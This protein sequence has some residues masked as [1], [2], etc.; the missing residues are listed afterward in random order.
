M[1]KTVNDH[2]A[3]DL[4]L[5]MAALREA[6]WHD[7]QRAYAAAAF[8]GGVLAAIHAARMAVPCHSPAWKALN[9]V[10]DA[11]PV[12]AHYGADTPKCQDNIEV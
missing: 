10:Y 7:C 8:H 2:L 1:H 3:Y 6:G 4:E 5:Y 9:D 12:G 11:L